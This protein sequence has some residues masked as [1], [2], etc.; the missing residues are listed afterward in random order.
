MDLAHKARHE[1]TGQARSHLTCNEAC[2]L[3]RNIEVR[4]AT[5]P[6]EDMKIVGQHTRLKQPSRKFYQNSG[7]VIDASQQDGLIQKRHTAVSQPGTGRP[8]VRIDF[9]RMIDVQNEYNRQAN[10]R[11]PVCQSRIDTRWQD[12]RLSR[13]DS[14]PLHVW[15]LLEGI[16]QTRKP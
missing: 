11:E 12:D 9:V 6:I 14:K 5:D 15:D 16:C 13:V 2:A 7:I 3:F 10:L 4:C 8:H 1:I